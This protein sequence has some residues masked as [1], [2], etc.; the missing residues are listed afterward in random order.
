MKS[1]FTRG[2]ISDFSPFARKQNHNYSI[3]K[4]HKSRIT[5]RFKK[6]QESGGIVQT[7]IKTAGLLGRIAVRTSSLPNL[8]Q[9]NK[10]KKN[11]ENED[12]ANKLNLTVTF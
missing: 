3:T 1:L 5:R 7:G 8:K 12:P 9:F 10:K 11:T 6:Q 2:Y 4:V